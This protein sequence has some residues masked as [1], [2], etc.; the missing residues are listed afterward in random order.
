MEGLVDRSRVLAEV[1]QVQVARSAN[2][3]KENVNIKQMPPRV[4]SEMN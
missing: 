1:E 3:G 2:S 4:L